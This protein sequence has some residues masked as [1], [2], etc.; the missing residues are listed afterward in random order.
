MKK[1]TDVMTAIYTNAMVTKDFQKELGDAG[2]DGPDVGGTGGRGGRGRGG[3]GTG[4]G[5]VPGEGTTK[6]T[7]S[8]GD[9]AMRMMKRLV[10]KHGWTP[11][12]AAAAAGH[13]HVESRINPFTKPGDYGTAHGTFQWRQNRWAALQAFRAAHK[14]E[15]ALDVDVDFFAQEVEHNRAWRAW[16]KSKNLEESFRYGRSFEGYRAGVT[17][18]EGERAAYMRGAYKRYREDKKTPGPTSEAAPVGHHRLAAS[19][20][21]AHTL[22]HHA[23]NRDQSINQPVTVNVTGFDDGDRIGRQVASSVN[24]VSKRMIRD[25]R[26][27]FA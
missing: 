4:G 13:S 25:F 10:E 20:L 14:G 1:L 21:G 18:H 8:E 27:K 23:D 12:A 22:A 24:N 17:A 26:T 3:R 16:A 7:G 5:A 6:P 15:D 19:A 2:F 11:E 9:R